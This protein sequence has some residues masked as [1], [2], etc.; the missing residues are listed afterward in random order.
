MTSWLSL[1]RAVVGPLLRILPT[2]ATLVAVGG[3]LWGLSFGAVRDYVWGDL[4]TGL[5]SLQGL[6]R[7]TRSLA[8]LGFGLMLAALLG[9]LFN[10]A[11]RNLFPLLS[12][13]ESKPSG[14]LLPLALVPASLFLLSMAWAFVLTGALHCH[15]SLRLGILAV[16]LAV[17][18][19]WIQ[20]ATSIKNGFIVYVMWG[21]LAAVAVVFAIRWGT[22]P[23]PA[24]EFVILLVLVAVIFVESQRFMVA[25]MNTS[26]FSLFAPRLNSN[27]LSL[28]TLVSPLLVLVGMDIASFA[29]RCAGWAT[30]VITTRLP[31]LLTWLILPLLLIWQLQDAIRETLRS[32]HAGGLG[33]GLL[34]YAMALG[35]PLTV[36][37]VWR[38][39]V[40]RTP[41]EPPP[42]VEPIATA[43]GRSVLPLI[44]AYL[45]PAL[46]STAILLVSIPLLVRPGVVEL[47]HIGSV[48]GWIATQIPPW[49]PW[50]ALLHV[51]AAAM[52]VWLS[53]R[54]QQSLALYLG[55]VGV[56]DLW[57]AMLLPGGPLSGL[58]WQG[59]R[60]VDFWW[61][62]L[63]A[64]VALAWLVRGGMTTERAGRLLFL[65][66]IITLVRQASFISDPFSPFLGFLGIGAVAFGI[67]WDVL[68]SGSWANATSRALPRVSRI[69]TYIGYVLLSVTILNWALATHNLEQTQVLTR[70]NAQFGFVVFGRPLLSA[71]FIVT[72]TLPASTG[73]ATAQDPAPGSRSEA[74]THPSRI[75]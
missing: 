45:A 4:R 73:S 68:T 43:A 63:L 36:W 7:A 15:W 58:G 54:G 42:G 55:I 69:F 23:R 13:Q 34:G 14:A 53:R 57:V 66:V 39:T 6:S 44:L 56:S 9:L 46:A 22:R 8:W 61:V 33:A 62:V 5:I 48:L 28:S 32:V 21:A 1:V 30:A 75:V 59:W 70:D 12:V 38:L 26:G 10:D 51:L 18:A 17:A 24:L 3:L 52:A 19:G 65:T 72:L 47:A 49:S 60:S 37:L 40:H 71:I 35:V 64:A 67:L 29:H 27:I 2:R 50:H 74:C 20:S 25:A 16:Y 41:D 31:R 11:W